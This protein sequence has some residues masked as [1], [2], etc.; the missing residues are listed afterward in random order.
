MIKPIKKEEDY[1]EALAKLHRF[2]RKGYVEG[3]PEADEA[4]VLAI[5]IHAYEEEHYPIPPPHPIEAI[6]FRMEQ[7]GMDETAL[8]KILGHKVQNNDILTGKRKL[9]LT[10]IRRLHEALKIPVETLV[11]AY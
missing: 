8:S 10:M 4:E 1:E 11:M 9:S 7:M 5:L 6:K 3:T 2:I